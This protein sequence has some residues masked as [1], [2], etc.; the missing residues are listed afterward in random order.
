[1]ES[2]PEVIYNR[3]RSV[4]FPSVLYMIEL[5]NITKKYGSVTAVDNLSLKVEKG[6]LFGFL[7]PNG[8]GKTTTIKM[9][10]GLA[11]PT[12]GC[13]LVCDFDIQKEPL[14]AKSVFGYIPDRPFLYEKLSG[15]EYLYFIGDIFGIDREVCRLKS[16]ELLEMLDLEKWGDELLE[17]YSHGMKQKIVFA[18]CFL[19]DPEVLLIDE[20]MVGLDPKGKEFIKGLLKRK[21]AEGM[22]VFMSTHSLEIVEEICTSIGIINEGKLILSGSLQKLKELSRSDKPGLTDIFL[23]LTEEQ[24]LSVKP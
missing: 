23:S 7:G 21:C 8:A 16:C 13:A 19:H 12:S 10:T 18:S 17:S 20:P 5:I 6:E 4:R 22:T 2:L 1:M 14:K 9:L 24:Y 11:R 3:P 15:R